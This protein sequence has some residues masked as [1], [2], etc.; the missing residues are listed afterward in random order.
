MKKL[1]SILWWISVIALSAISC[2]FAYTQEQQEAYK[3]AYKYGLTTQSTIDAAKM[4]SP[5]TRQAFA[6]MVVKYLENVVWVKQLSSNS[7]YFTDE[8]KITNDLKLY[9]KKACAYQVMW[10]NWNKFSPTQPVDRAQLWTVFSRI[11]WWDT[12]NSTWKWYYIYHVNALQ[13]A[14]IMNNIKNVVGVHAKRWDV[15]IMFKRMYNKFGSNVYL[16][17]WSNNSIN[18]KNNLTNKSSNNSVVRKTDSN[19]F[20][21]YDSYLDNP[22]LSN[23]MKDMKLRSTYCPNIF[24]QQVGDDGTY[25]NQKH[26]YWD[27]IEWTMTLIP[28]VYYISDCEYYDKIYW[29]GNSTTSNVYDVEDDYISSVY[30]N[31]NIVYT[32]KD[33]TMYYYDDKFLTMLMDVAEKKWESGLAEYLKIEAQ[34]FKNWLDQLSDLDDEELLKS[35]WID[36]DNLDPDKMTKQEK[37]ELIKKLKSALGKIIDENKWKNNNLLKDL[38]KITKNIKDDKFWLK[39]KYNKTKTFI[40]ASN[41]FLDLYSE[42]IF[43]LMELALMEEEE[44]SDEWMA[45]AFWLIWIALAYQWTAQEYQEYVEEWA[46]GTVEILWLKSS[47]KTIVEDMVKNNPIRWDKNA[48]FTIIEYTELLCPYCQ[49]HSSDGTI[50]AVIKKFPGEVNSVTKHFIIHWDEAL[51]LASAME[52]IAELKPSVYYKAF[53]KSFDAYPVNLEWMIS[54]AGELGINKTSLQSCINW[55]KY[56]Q[57][58]MD[59]MNQAS[60]LF[61]VNGTPGNVI[62]DRKTGNYKLVSG[63]YPVDEFVSTIN[64]LKKM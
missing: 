8:N 19:G 49:R 44:G 51:K 58:I 9:A 56:D 35:M 17:N 47:A 46:V 22:R 24:C 20:S 48:R 25:S 64:E 5:I 36:I 45:Q 7:C 3:W 21:Y 39:E 6:K 54:I 55:W 53:E 13:S 57:K 59:S 16:N 41:E 31:S 34:Y 38:G 23:A 60:E 33:G 61:W 28:W 29:N 63:A 1:F 62:I 32:W 4:N 50:D 30:S 12:Y 26:Y 52:C 14:W 11:L 18:T 43:N 27:D 10:L 2:T 40:E 42:S 37:Q 15:M